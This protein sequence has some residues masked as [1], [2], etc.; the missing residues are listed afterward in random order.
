MK[1]TSVIL[2]AFL[3]ISAMLLSLVSCD[4][5]KN[6]KDTDESTAEKTAEQDTKNDP[7]DK[8]TDNTEESS[9]EPEEPSTENI[10]EKATETETFEEST[11]EP[12]KDT[13]YKKLVVIGDSISTGYGL[14]GYSAGSENQSV[15][16]FANS[17]AR[18]YGLTYGESFF[19]LAVDGYKSADILSKIK[20]NTAILKDADLILITAGGN[21]LMLPMFSALADVMGASI[22]SLSE[23]AALLK[24]LITADEATTEALKASY[25]E[26]KDSIDASMQVLLDNF[27]S[28]LDKINDEI[29]KVAPD[30][31]IVIQTIYDPLSESMFSQAAVKFVDEAFAA[32]YLGKANDVIKAKAESYSL[33]LIDTAELFKGS[34]IMYT[35]IGSA[36]IHPNAFGHSRIA[37]AIKSAIVKPQ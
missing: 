31:K 11:A 2:I 5:G 1:K 18:E 33:V 9:K 8:P 20:S 19:N 32:N 7:T 22:T 27:A 29:K 30:A 17:V 3:L 10:T 23:G 14:A 6:D 16:N 24:S 37:T 15:Q 13:G 25:A 34:A 36:D 28:N 26:K 4:N 35:N 12:E 21:D